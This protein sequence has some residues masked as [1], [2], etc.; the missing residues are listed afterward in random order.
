MRKK[1]T[2]LIKSVCD[3]FAK[4]LNRLC[5]EAKK[6]LQAMSSRVNDNKLMTPNLKFYYHEIT[7]LT[8]I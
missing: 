7:N 1:E 3:V 2:E 6:R 5:N 8:I 4:L